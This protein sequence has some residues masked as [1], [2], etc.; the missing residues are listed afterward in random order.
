MTREAGFTLVE[1]LVV[2]ALT[3]M[4][5]LAGSTLLVGTLRASDRLGKTTS[6]MNEID[7]A[8]TLMRDDFANAVTIAGRFGRP[9]DQTRPFVAFVRD[10]WN[11]PGTDEMRA[12]LLAVEYRYADGTLT[13]RTWLRPDPVSATPYV[14]R[15]LASGL[16]RL[17]ARYFTGR[18]WLPEWSGDRG[19]LPRAVELRLEYSETDAL[20]ELFVMGGGG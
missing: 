7:I 13:R 8:H 5:V 10:G 19:E 4:I 14:D 9:Q 18:E 12:T 6:A 2:L 1:M 11:H 17:T 20:T 3:S 16:T 15:V